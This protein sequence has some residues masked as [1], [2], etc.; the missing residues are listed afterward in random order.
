LELL[1]IDRKKR[2]KTTSPKGLSN[3]SYLI[4]QKNT[5]YNKKDNSLLQKKLIKRFNLN[6]KAV[7]IAKGLKKYSYWKRI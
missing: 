1:T 7:N 5:K 6:I 4:R 2:G 3:L